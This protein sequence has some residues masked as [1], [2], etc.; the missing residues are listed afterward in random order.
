MTKELI[1]LLI[2]II[3]AVISFLL[4]RE[5]PAQIARWVMIVF[6]SAVVAVLSAGFTMMRFT[7]RCVEEPANCAPNQLAAPW[8]VG[9]IEYNQTASC[10]RCAE[11]NG[12]G[13]LPLLFSINEI[14][15]FA[16]AVSALLCACLSAAI[17]VRF[18]AW[19]RVQRASPQ[20]NRK[21][22]TH[23]FPTDYDSHCHEQLN[24][25]ESL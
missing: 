2:A 13:E 22:D 15:P 3:P 8:H 1:E 5:R 4:W 21:Q 9:L 11:V 25:T 10:L 23:S 16:S 14:T 17:L 7:V 24:S 12:N 19:G 18:A 20:E 6:A